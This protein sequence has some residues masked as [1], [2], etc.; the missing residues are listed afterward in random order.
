MNLS[1]QVDLKKTELMNNLFHDVLEGKFIT[2]RKTIVSD[3]EDIFNWRTSSSGR[4]LRQ[5]DN[6]SI[7]S[8]EN[9]IKSRGY[10]EINYIIYNLK[11]GEKVGAI[12]IYDVNDLDK[13]ANVGR[14]LLN[15]KLLKTSNPFGLEALLM[16][17]DYVLNKMDFRKI[18]GEISGPNES[19]Y[20]LQ[21]FLGMKQEGFLEKHI[22]LNDE[23]HDLYIMSIFRENF[24]TTY[25]KKI[26]FL[27]KNFN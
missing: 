5:P 11:T 7:K 23:F 4:Y 26:L 10:N 2:L 6:Y 17:Y 13:V 15:E 27:L 9:W 3:A 18:T 20:K 14:L 24:N 16:C 1:N 21:K 19:V 12:A 25:K 22:L 8:Q